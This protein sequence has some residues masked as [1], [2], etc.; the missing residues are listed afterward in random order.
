MPSVQ[1]FERGP[2]REALTSSAL[3]QAV[4]GF[5]GQVAG[6]Q[7]RRSVNENRL[8]EGQAILD[9][10]N[11]TQGQ[12]AEAIFKITNDPKQVAA[13]LPQMLAQRR[14]QS[15]Y[16]GGQQGG[17][18]AP[19]MQQ[20]GMDNQSGM[21]SPMM[22]P[23]QQQAQPQ[24]PQSN[25][26][27]NG[28][29]AS[30][31]TPGLPQPGQRTS[32][33][34]MPK[35][36]TPEEI[37][38]KSQQF[39]MT[40][41]MGDPNAYST[42]QNNLIKQNQLAENQLAELQNL[43]SNQGVTAQEMPEFLR[44]GQR[45]GYMKDRNEWLINTKRDYQEYKQNKT[46]LDNAFVPGFFTGLFKGPKSR[47][48]SLNNLNGT[49]KKLVDQGFEQ[50]VRQKLA[51]EYL[52]PTEIEERIHPLQKKTEMELSNLKKGTF[53]KDEIEGFDKGTPSRKKSPF[54]YEEV[55][56]KEPKAID[57][58]NKRL[59]DFLKKN[60]DKETS[61]LVLRDKLWNKDYDWRQ[62]SDAM[63]MA[64][65]GRKDLTQAQINEMTQL[66]TQAP[67]QSLSDV[68]SDWWRIIGNIRGQK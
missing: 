18:M 51:S 60:V 2:S 28:Q 64:F 22:Q 61:L 7:L 5:G 26:P 6:E 8:K 52:S 67:T 33:G 47:E 43:A 13:M 12:L 46:S 1:F 53:P 63:N 58:Q 3:G 41:G 42:E 62:I 36:L 45:Y 37:H 15:Y 32:S 38:Q 66:E 50:E 23:N 19:G 59:A 9:N 39:A 16:G 14:A 17:Q 54:S 24:R 34:V 57:A 48:D 29:F 31:N 11:A 68:F 56:E 10:P 55:L 35:I 4:G 20:P 25:T 30:E 65:P 21:Q 49:V 44:V 27:S 40:M